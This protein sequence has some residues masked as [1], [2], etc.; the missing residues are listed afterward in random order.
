MLFRDQRLGLLGIQCA[1]A[2]LLVTVTACGHKPWLRSKTQAD[3]VVPKLNA[4]ELDKLLS[5]METRLSQSLSG[6]RLASDYRAR[7][8]AYEQQDR[9]IKFFEKILVVQPTNQRARLELGCAFVD[10]IPTCGGMA[11]IVSKGT[12]ARKSLDQFDAYLVAEPDS[13]IGHYTRGI[14]HLHWPRALRHSADAVQDL[15][16]CL[17]LQQRTGKSG[18]KSYYLLPYVALGDAH[19]KDSQMAEARQT[20]RQGL[21]IFPEA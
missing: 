1:L 10:K 6:Y 3:E 19:T 20:W 17:E 21:K 14:N 9:A 2:V 4:A 18:L 7:C 11:A 13:W 15:A 8:A 16:R 5:E 12:L